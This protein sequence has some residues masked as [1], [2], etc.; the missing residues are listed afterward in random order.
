MGNGGA[1][2][3]PG[4]GGLSLSCPLSQAGDFPCPSSRRVWCIPRLPGR[5]ET[6]L[7][8][9]TLR[10][11]LRCLGSSRLTE[12]P[13]LAALHPPSS[14]LPM[15]TSGHI[16]TFHCSCFHPKPFPCRQCCPAAPGLLLGQAPHSALTRVM[17]SPTF[18]TIPRHPC[19]ETV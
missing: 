17:L 1:G 6:P 8:T 19:L 7:P 13:E 12:P 18:S 3:C 4:T 5:S 14:P 2:L 9:P 15:R 11:L 10:L 16:D